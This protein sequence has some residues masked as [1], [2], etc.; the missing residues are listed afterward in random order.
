M[1]KVIDIDF[2]P[3]PSGGGMTVRAVGSESSLVLV[4]MAGDTTRRQSKPSM[5]QILGGEF[6]A[7]GRWNVLRCV[8]GPA[9]YADVLAVERIPGL[10]VIETLRR[11]IPVD[12]GEILTVVIR[13]ALD[14]GCPLWPFAGIGGVEA[15]VLDQL[16]LD[17]LVAIDTAK[18]GRPGGYLVAL[19][20]VGGSLETVV[21]LGK[22][23]R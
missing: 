14:A 23:P 4:L 13:M 19:Y 1:V 15:L 6:G 8:A 17:L 20:A 5:I 9:A 21:G 18:G 7:R 10:G 3:L 2:G 11:G 12:E 16:G 22:G